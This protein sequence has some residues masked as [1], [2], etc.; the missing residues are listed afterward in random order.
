MPSYE[1]EQIARLLEKLEVTPTEDKEYLA[2]ITAE[3]HLQLLRENADHSEII[4]FAS[5][6]TVF[7]HV[8]LAEGVSATPSDIVDLLEWNSTPFTGRAAFYW[9]GGTRDVQVDFTADSSLPR[10][11]K[12]RQNLVFGRKMEGMDEPYYYE[13]LQEFTHATDI[14][15]SEEQQA[16]CRYDENGEIDPVVSVTKSDEKCEITLVTCKREPLEQ[17]LAATERALVRFFEFRM[18][19]RDKSIS[20]AEGVIE[21]KVESPFLSYDQ[22][23]IPDG[24]RVYPWSAIIAGNNRQGSAVWIN[25]G[26]RTRTERSAICELYR[27]RLEE[28]QDKRRIHCPWEIHQLLC[29][30]R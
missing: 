20:W 29:S 3:G 6:R 16:Y 28:R 7:T 24:E 26:S 21:R 5:S 30:R 10:N 25:Y 2:W 11:L 13:L 18:V 1:H 27:L 19:K 14:H 8:E 15:W 23:V 12:E 22:W 9:T 4:V 17:Y